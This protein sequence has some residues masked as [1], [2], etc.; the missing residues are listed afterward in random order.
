MAPKGDGQ[1]RSVFL[2][3]NSWVVAVP[4]RVRAHL[5]LRPGRP[6]Y[7]H[8]TGPKEGTITPHPQ[9]VGGKPPGLDLAGE[10]QAARREVERLRRKVAERPLRVFNQGAGAGVKIVERIGYVFDD[11]LRAVHDDLAAILAELG[12]R[13]PRRRGRA[14]RPRA[15]QHRPVEALALPAPVPSPPPPPSL[16]SSGGDAASGEERPQAAQL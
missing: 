4:P 9:R 16:D 8:L 12:M 11:R 6:V 7:W 5:K 15:Y 10:L 14:R 13:S 3:G 1:Q 2:L